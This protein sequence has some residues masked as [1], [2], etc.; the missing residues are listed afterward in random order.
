MSSSTDSSF[1]KEQAS[2][3]RPGNASRSAPMISGASIVSQSSS[4]SSGRLATEQHL[5][6]G[7][8]AQAETESLERDHLVRRDV[9]DV[10]VQ[11]E[12][13]DEPRLARLGGRL[14]DQ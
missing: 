11:A 1:W 8:A 14:E 5:L 7:V 6:E 3:T 12:A 10:D 9:S 13:L 2:E 4:G